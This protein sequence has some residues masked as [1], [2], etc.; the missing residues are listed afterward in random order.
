MLPTVGVTEFVCRHA[1]AI[2]ASSWYYSMLKLTIL[3]LKRRTCHEVKTRTSCVCRNP[4]L[5]VSAVCLD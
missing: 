3:D 2:M 4:Q 1:A 5:S